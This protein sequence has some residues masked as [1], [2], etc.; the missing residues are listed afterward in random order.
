M[1][2]GILS[3]DQFDHVEKSG[4][5]LARAS[6]AGQALLHILQN[7]TINGRSFFIAPR[8]WAPDGYV[9]LDIDD[10]SGNAMLQEIQA[11]QI[12]SAPLELGLFPA[13]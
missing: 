5:T 9:D 1:R 6:D 10:Y 13:Q 3:K 4:V 11:E 7:D 12:A 2:T 8:K